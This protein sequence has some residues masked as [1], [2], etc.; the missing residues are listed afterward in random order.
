MTP[1]EKRAILVRAKAREFASMVRGC[2][3]MAFSVPDAIADWLTDEEV[4]IFFDHCRAFRI[5]Q[6][7]DWKWEARP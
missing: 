3:G 7:D 4:P 1:A 2:P 6:R 5:V